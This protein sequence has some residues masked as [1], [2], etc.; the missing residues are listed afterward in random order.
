MA[1]IHCR[2]HDEVT[3][4]DHLIVLCAVES[5]EVNRP[6]TP[7]LFFQGGYGGFNPRHDRPR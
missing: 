1:H 2:P 4:G 6:A 3:A 7:L 5:M